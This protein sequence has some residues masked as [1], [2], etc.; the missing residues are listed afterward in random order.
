MLRSIGSVVLL[1]GLSVVAGVVVTEADRAEASYPGG[2]GRVAYTES[3]STPSG[4]YFSEVYT[5]DPDG[6]DRRRVTF[7]GGTLVKTEVEADGCSSDGYVD[8]YTRSS[9]P[10][11][12]PDGSVLAFLHYAAN[13][14]HEIRTIDPFSGNVEVLFS[15]WDASMLS[16]SPDGKRIAY[17]DESGVWVANADGTSAV[18]VAEPTLGLMPLLPGWPSTIG[19]VK[20]SPDGSKLA[21]VEGARFVCGGG[22]DYVMVVDVDGSNRHED[23]CNGEPSGRS[24]EFDWAPDG[25]KL[26]CEGY[27]EDFEDG[28]KLMSV[29]PD[30]SNP[31]PLTDGGR[32]VWSPD[33]SEILFVFGDLWGDDGELWSYDTSSKTTR[34]VMSGFS[35]Y[36]MDWQPEPLIPQPVGLVDPD[37]GIWR[38]AD[39]DGQVTSF[40]YGN[41]GDFPIMGDWDCSGTDTPGLYRQTDGFVYLRN[42]N[43]QGNADIRF[44]FGNPG[45]I[46]LA[47]DFN[48]D[49]CDTVSI[50]RQLEGR[51]YIINELGENDGGLG[52][53]DH[54]FYF[55]N[56]GDKP[57]VGDFDGNDIDT[58]GLHRES[59]GLVY[60]RNTNT[61]GNAEFEFYFGDPGD[62]LIAGDWNGDETDSPAVYRPSSSTFYF[63]YTNTQGN[64]DEQFAWG[65]PHWLPV[66]AQTD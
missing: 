8:Y 9:S 14:T 58:V 13:D 56:P 44:Y 18:V 6:S 1:V 17:A 26:V 2:P 60:F 16:W 5:M 42:S 28:Y 7:D 46:P 27:F 10:R 61:Q 51:V 30:G 41:P 3:D 54:D 38:V 48:G 65:R 22:A 59:T 43:T 31:I 55:G 21:F 33:G 19:R 20:W 32:P 11:W 37:T 63:R 24:S 52:A 49:G 25:Q 53:A 4:G 50:Y 39:N 15:D 34:R 35:G 47:G 57:F 40:Y 23:L 66:S 12:S 62:R 29:E 36:T 64:A 45:D